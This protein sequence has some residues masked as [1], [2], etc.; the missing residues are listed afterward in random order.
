MLYL[1]VGVLALAI[2]FP[3]TSRPLFR[4]EAGGNLERWITRYCAVRKG[5][6]R[7]GNGSLICSVVPMSPPQC[8]ADTNCL[9]A[10]QSAVGALRFWGSSWRK[11]YEKSCRCR[12]ERW[13]RIYTAASRRSC[14]PSSL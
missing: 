12:V 10:R 8:Q 5:F 1:P 2:A 13:A 11:E 14:C 9:E 4:H 3:G 7:K 6:L